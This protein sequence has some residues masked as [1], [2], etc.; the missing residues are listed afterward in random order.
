MAASNDRDQNS[1]IDLFAGAGGWDI[2]A[3][4]IGIEPLGI[5]FDKVTCQAREAAD[6]RTLCA[7]QQ[8]GNAIPPPLAEAI[9]RSLML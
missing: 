8:I 4:K 1:V 9:L 3:R 7:D 2:A 6:L 5:E